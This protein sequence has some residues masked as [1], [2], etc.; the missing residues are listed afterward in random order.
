MCSYVANV[1]NC[2]GMWKIRADPGK[3]SGKDMEM[4]SK[5]E[6]F[7]HTAAQIKLLLSDSCCLEFQWHLLVSWTNK[8]YWKQQAEDQA[9]NKNTMFFAVVGAHVSHISVWW[10]FC[11]EWYKG[12]F[13][14]CFLLLEGSHSLRE[15]CCALLVGVNWMRA[16]WV[17]RMW[18]N[19]HKKLK[20][21][22][23]NV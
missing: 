3:V 2:P 13:W 9:F 17:I 6:S 5:V 15:S 16:E 19:K 8:K 18:P 14:A 12:K 7:Y 22:T 21:K 4:W 11:P 10:A 1:Q 23:W 20:G